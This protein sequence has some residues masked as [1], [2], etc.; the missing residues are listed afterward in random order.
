LSNTKHI[1]GF[2]PIGQKPRMRIMRQNYLVQAIPPNR[3]AAVTGALS[4]RKIRWQ[5]QNPMTRNPSSVNFKR[6]TV[7]P[8]IIR[9]LIISTIQPKSLSFAAGMGHLNSSLAFTFE[10]VRVAAN[11]LP[12]VENR[13]R[14]KASI[15]K[16]TIS[17]N[18]HQLHS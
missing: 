11:A 8:L 6:S 16:D 5:N 14:A 4:K 9:R 12:N 7:A 10:A 2:H 17:N 15:S 18:N 13:R 1:A 3:N